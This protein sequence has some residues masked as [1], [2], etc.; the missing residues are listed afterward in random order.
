MKNLYK[1]I[2]ILQIC[3]GASL[4]PTFALADGSAGTRGGGDVT[5]AR[6]VQ[7]AVEFVSLKNDL[8]KFL[9]T[10]DVCQLQAKSVKELYSD[11]TAK[12]LLEDIDGTSYQLSDHCGDD[13]GVG[14][15]ASTEIG[16]RN[17]PICFNLTVMSQQ[18]TQTGELLGLALHEHAHHFGVLDNDASYLLI[19]EIANSYSR[20]AIQNAND[21]GHSLKRD[22]RA[23]VTVWAEL[24]Q[25]N[26][27]TTNFMDS[28][29]ISLSNFPITISGTQEIM[30]FSVQL[31]NVLVAGRGA[32]RKLSKPN[33][34]PMTIASLLQQGSREERDVRWFA[35][36]MANLYTFWQE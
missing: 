17:A 33:G 13:Q 29:S 9:S 5:A 32:K 18:N 6:K 30:I 28:G 10:M 20:Q 27:I 7:I 24:F 34:Y 35:D 23:H 36:Q 14:H 21:D 3:V 16:K 1:K 12:G 19:S 8:K 4:L 15:A 22:K 2:M 31:D 26:Q 11:I 25:L